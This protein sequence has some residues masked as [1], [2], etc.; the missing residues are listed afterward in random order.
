MAFPICNSLYLSTKGDKSLA[1]HQIYRFLQFIEI[2][3]IDY[4]KT[5]IKAK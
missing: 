5:G 4:I 3:L 1:N 2:T